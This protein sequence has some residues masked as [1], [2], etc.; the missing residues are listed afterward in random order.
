[1]VFRL[2]IALVLACAASAGARSDLCRAGVPALEAGDLV[3]ATRA[4]QRGLAA[5]PG[6][7]YCL[8][9]LAQAC[10][11]WFEHKALFYEEAVEA[12]EE[13]LGTLEDPELPGPYQEARFLLGKILVSG[14][15]YDRAAEHLKAFLR[16]QPAYDSLEEVW[17]TLGVAHYYLDQYEEAVRA[18]EK[19]LETDADYGPARFNL[20]SVF[21]RLSLFDVAMANRRAGH[22]VPALKTFDQL[23]GVAPRYGPAH[24]QKALVLRELSRLE[25]GEA[26]AQLALAL[27]PDP[28]VAFGLREFLGDVLAAQGRGEEALP[29]YRRCLQ[30]FPGYVQVVEKMDAIEKGLEAGAAASPAGDALPGEPAAPAPG[31]ALP[32]AE[33]PL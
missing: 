4:F 12:Y 25:E 33:F 11:A 27:G 28:K 9:L 23:L 32:V 1:M 29:Q 20:R 13:V 18:F 31:P 24:L 7:K 3:T 8:F 14:G 15:E 26:A 6:S 22:F 17:N 19:A 10:H 5:D 21:T 16:I 2:A 30:I